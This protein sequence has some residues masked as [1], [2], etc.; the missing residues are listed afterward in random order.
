VSCPDIIQEIFF[1]KPYVDDH[2]FDSPVQ[3]PRS[4][5][6]PRKSAPLYV[7]DNF[8]ALPQLLRQKVKQATRIQ[9]FS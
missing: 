8:I 7:S 1:D 9:I 3:K 4:I 6:Q 5:V 2:A